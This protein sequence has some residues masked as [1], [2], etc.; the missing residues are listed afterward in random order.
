MTA[1]DRSARRTRRLAS[2]LVLACSLAAL[3]GVWLPQGARS[4]EHNFAGSLQTNYLGV[5]TDKDAFKQTLD[6]FTNELSIKVAVDFN[7]NVSANVKLCYGCHGVELGMAF[8]DLRIIDELNF[9]IG[10]FTPAF[11]DFPLRHDPA[12]HRTSDKPLPYDMGRMLRMREFNFG[13]LPAPYV[14]QGI[15]ISGTHW[16]GDD[17]QFDYA[18]HA[19]GGLR[20]SSDELDLDFI[21]SRSVY[22]VD[23]NSEPAVGGRLALTIDLSEDVLLTVGGSVMAGRPDT[24]REL[25]Y[26][27]AGADVYLRLWSFDLHAEYLIRRQQFPLG[28]DPDNTFRYGPNADGQYDDFF[29]KD[30]FYIEGTLPVSQRIELVARFD[31]LRRIGN[32]TINSPLRER[33]GMLRYTAG[34]NVVLD[35]SV[36][37]KFSGEVYDFSDFD[38]EVAL[39]AGV[40]AAF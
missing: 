38:D 20:S 34:L 1:R 19:I 17:V 13:V 31:G 22:Y 7:D 2:G 28:D 5:V 35:G 30:G 9:R 36:R 25:Y 39:N 18:V 15:E 11:G 4:Q 32:V 21:K 33:S 23:N 6:G 8:A 37:L 14:D 24:S 27:I 29:I 3:A 12:N 16:F 40:A 10:R 26:A